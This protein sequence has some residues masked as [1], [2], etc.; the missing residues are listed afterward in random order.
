MA[1]LQHIYDRA[2][3]HRLHGT[4]IM[5]PMTLTV[6]LLF[7]DSVKVLPVLGNAKNM[8]P[9]TCK[10]HLQLIYFKEG[11]QA[12]IF[13]NSGESGVSSFRL[14]QGSWDVHKDTEL[15]PYEC[16]DHMHMT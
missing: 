4:C 9:K 16:I 2:N 12:L 8:L 6:S 11:K 14:A 1:R 7:D 15:I 13:A 5:P 3:A 10:D